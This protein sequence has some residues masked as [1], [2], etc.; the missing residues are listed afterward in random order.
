MKSVSQLLFCLLFLVFQGAALADPPLAA[1]DPVLGVEDLEWLEQQDS[2][3]VGI[4]HS[5]V[6]LVFDTGD[7]P[8]AGIWIDYLQRIEN[9]LGVLVEPELLDGS[10][11]QPEPDI[12]L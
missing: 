3:R 1:P 7:G 11:N 10:G 12:I 8:L 6:P 9:K 2:F 5:Q 4:R